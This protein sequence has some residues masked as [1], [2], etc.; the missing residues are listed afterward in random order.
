MNPSPPATNMFM[1]FLPCFAEDRGQRQRIGV[2]SQRQSTEHTEHTELRRT[3][4][5]RAGVPSEG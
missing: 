4:F 1:S 5:V 2:C 3:L